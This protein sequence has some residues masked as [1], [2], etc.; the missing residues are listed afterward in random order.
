MEG[1]RLDLE[2][3]HRLAQV[4]P[5]EQ[6]AGRSVASQQRYLVLADHALGE[7][8]DH[9]AHLGGKRGGRSGLERTRQRPGEVEPAL[10]ALCDRIEHG[11]ERA[12]VHGG[13]LLAGD[14]LRSGQRRARHEPRVGGHVRLHLGAERGHVGIRALA[15][16]RA[17]R[18]TR[19][20]PGERPVDHSQEEASRTM[21]SEPGKRSSASRSAS[22]VTSIGCA[23]GRPV[24]EQPVAAEGHEDEQ[25]A[26]V[27]HRA[28]A[29]A[30][31]AEVSQ[32]ELGL[33]EL[34]RRAHVGH[35]QAD[36]AQLQKQLPA[37]RALARDQLDQVPG[38]VVEVGRP[39]AP[40][41]EGDIVLQQLDTLAREGHGLLEAIR[42]DVEGHVGADRRAGLEAQTGR[43]RKVGV[44]AGQCL[45]FGRRQHD[46]PDPHSEGSSCLSSTTGANRSPC[47]STRRRTSAASNTSVAGSSSSSHPS[48]AE[49]VGRSRAL[50]E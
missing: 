5:D 36:F 12:Q 22:I 47:S 9:E 32:A 40:V 34:H 16:A 6:Q 2:L 4:G 45:R 1:V 41:R 31:P 21:C 37:R 30:V 14:E 7:V 48:G 26:V 28:E 24:C 20:L 38:R 29:L 11:G 15:V 17:C 46:L 27:A 10:Q 43:A 8:A 3:A 33:E 39:R 35:G 44:K 42:R 19:H 49:T 25:T 13:P 50:S 18:E 23:G